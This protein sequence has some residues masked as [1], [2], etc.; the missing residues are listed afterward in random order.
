MNFADGMGL[1]E[2]LSKPCGGS[3]TESVAKSYI[4]MFDKLFVWWKLTY[5]ATIDDDSNCK[6][7]QDEM[8][9]RFIPVMFEMNIIISSMN[10]DLVTF[11][12]EVLQKEDGLRPTSQLNY[13][14]GINNIIFYFNYHLTL[15]FYLLFHRSQSYSTLVLKS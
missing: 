15:T 4:R 5:P 3:L 13:L 9:C 8:S 10:V 12:E 6:L 11:I 2:Y 7:L 1:K 14:T